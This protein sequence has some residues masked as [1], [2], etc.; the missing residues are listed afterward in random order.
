MQLWSTLFACYIVKSADFKWDGSEEVGIC[1]LE[2]HP[3]WL[4]LASGIME[5]VPVGDGYGGNDSGKV[6]SL[7]IIVVMAY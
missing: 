7:D 5:E 1:S 2:E 6:F 4:L 3:E